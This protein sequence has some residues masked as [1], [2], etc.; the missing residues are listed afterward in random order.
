MGSEKGSTSYFLKNIACA[1]GAA[2]ITVSFIHPID[3]VKTRLQ[4]SGEKGRVGKTYNGVGDVIKTVTAEEGASAFY[5]GIGA[6][7]MREAS[8]TSLRSSRDVNMNTRSFRPLDHALTGRSMVHCSVSSRWCSWAGSRRPSRFAPPTCS[9]TG[10]CT[11][12]SPPLPQLTQSAP[13]GVRRIRSCDRSPRA[14]TPPRA[15]I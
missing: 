1:G 15:S 10:A 6:A 2:V 12:G 4:I 5:K 8:Y 11:R 9:Q 7:W 3:V 14:A 13:W